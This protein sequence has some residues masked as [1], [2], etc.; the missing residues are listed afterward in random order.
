MFGPEGRDHV[1]PRV[2]E[3]RVASAVR[4]FGPGHLTEEAEVLSEG[5]AGE[6]IRLLGELKIVVD[7]LMS[8]VV[9]ARGV[10]VGHLRVQR[11]G[12]IA[13]EIA[14]EDHLRPHARVGVRTEGDRF[15][16]DLFGRL[17]GHPVTVQ[18]E[19]LSER[20]QLRK[21]RVTRLTGCLV[22][23]REGGDGARGARVDENQPGG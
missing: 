19:G 13:R 17:R 22:L 9:P 14:R 8:G 12:R 23:A 21:D 11:E 5:P 10:D 20:I 18:P 7:D 15:L 1:D 4:P 6:E 16:P 3:L 2:L